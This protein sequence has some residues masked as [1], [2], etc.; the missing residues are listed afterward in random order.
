MTNRFSILALLLLALSGC[1][2]FS[3]DFAKFNHQLVNSDYDGARHLAESKINGAERNSLLW[4]LQAGVAA[5]SSRDYTAST[6]FFDL[7]EEQIKRYHEYSAFR[8]AGNKLASL[9]INDKALPYEGTEY[10]GI[11][12]NTYKALNYL[13]A[14]KYNSARVEFN[15]AL[16]RQRRAKEYFFD[17]IGKEREALAIRQRQE[18]SSKAKVKFDIDET[19]HSSQVDSLIQNGYSRFSQFGVYPDFVNPFT[20]YLAGLFF[21]LDGDFAK[22]VPLLKEAKGMLPENDVVADDFEMVDDVLDKR[23]E[24]PP[25]TVWL[26]FENGRAPHK[27]EY[28]VD[29]P[30]SLVNDQILYTGIAL[31]R[32]VRGEEASPYLEV[33]SGGE[34]IRTTELASMDRVIQTEFKKNYKTIVIRALLSALMKTSMQYYL[35]DSELG[36]MGKVAASMLQRVTT[37][38]D[39]RIWSALPQNFQ[40]ARLPRPENGKLHITSPELE[41][42][43]VDLPDSRY[44]IIYITVPTRTT[45]PVIQVIPFKRWQPQNGPFVR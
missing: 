4:V 37:A 27:E 20:T 8:S 13:A 12:V 30:L 6:V 9:L 3:S 26:L 21:A 23:V 7:A 38:A 43:D 44:A 29:L 33:A 28:R 35:N 42:M 36:E 16:D 25:A 11:M 31:P 34:S 10:D 5:R 1:S 18:H 40:V 14:N 41:P 32:L 24:P 45:R 19:V 17:E 15:R 39:L 22:A 2:T